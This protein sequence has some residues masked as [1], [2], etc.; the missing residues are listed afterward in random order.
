MLID[1]GMIELYLNDTTLLLRLQ[2][3]KRETLF[4]LKVEGMEAGFRWLLRCWLLCGIVALQGCGS[5][6]G[7]TKER[8]EKWIES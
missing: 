1:D 3:E 7:R 4:W 8:I 2:V 5:D 6:G